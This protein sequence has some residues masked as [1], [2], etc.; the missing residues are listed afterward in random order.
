MEKNMSQLISVE[1]MLDALFDRA[2]T[3]ENGLVCCK[4]FVE[5][6]KY[7]VAMALSD[8]YIT[9]F[10]YRT[11]DDMYSI[12][13]QQ[14]DSDWD[15]T[16]EKIADIIDCPEQNEL[17]VSEYAE[18]WY[19]RIEPNSDIISAIVISFSFYPVYI[20][21]NRTFPSRKVNSYSFYFFCPKIS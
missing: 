10:V 16:A 15:D 4:C 17:T 19:S 11:E 14:Y 18:Y 21:S 8:S 1:E 13:Y 12:V 5:N 3:S 9:V 20:L 2:D 6:R 7:I